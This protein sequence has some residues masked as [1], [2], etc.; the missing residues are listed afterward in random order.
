MSN[1]FWILIGFLVYFLTICLS[2]HVTRGKLG[3]HSWCFGSGLASTLNGFVWYHILLRDGYL[4]EKEGLCM[5]CLVIG[6]IG[7][8]LMAV[9][10]LIAVRE[11]R[12]Q[13]DRLSSKTKG[14]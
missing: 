6:L 5:F 2:V 11:L 8:V 10:I 4:N 12:E 3:A 9:D 14:S 1:S 13:L 7:I